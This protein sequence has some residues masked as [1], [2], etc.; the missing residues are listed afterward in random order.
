MDRRQRYVPVP[1]SPCTQ[2][3]HLN[4]NFDKTTELTGNSIVKVYTHL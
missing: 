2:M 3:V 4:G 1:A